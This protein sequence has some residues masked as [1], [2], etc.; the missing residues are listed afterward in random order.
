MS[1]GDLCFVIMSYGK[2]S[3]PSGRT[4]D[5]DRLYRDAIKPGIQ[6]AGLEPIRADEEITNG[7]IHT[8]M[9]ERLVLCKFTVADIT[10]ASANVF[11]E[12]G[13]RHA[14]KPHTTLMLFA[15]SEK[16]PFD[17]NLMRAHAYKL[18]EAGEAANPAEIIEMIRT[19][20][21]NAK[22]LAK[23]AS[24]SSDSPLFELLPGYPDVREEHTK[25]FQDQVREQQQLR[26][27]IADATTAPAGRLEQLQRI[28]AELESTQ[29][30][31]EAVTLE[32]YLA[33]RDIANWKAMEALHA[34]MHPILS[35][36]VIVR[37]Q[38]ALCLNRMKDGE[39]AE[40]VLLA[41]ID[42]YGPTGERYGLLGRVFKDRWRRAVEKKEE[43]EARD[44]LKA[45]ISY[46]VRGFEI[47]DFDPYPGVN[48]VTCMD[49]QGGT[50]PRLPELLTVV[51]FVARTRRKR[52]KPNYW[53]LA[54]ALELAVLAGDEPE[55]DSI[56]DDMTLTKAHAWQYTTT[57]DNLKDI[58][59]ARVARGESS[60]LAKRF[61]DSL[62]RKSTSTSDA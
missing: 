39:N 22:K 21:E 43:Q 49:I 42:E 44:M 15:D 4:V 53:D 47:G 18:N 45:A 41:L 25:S 19:K 7:V 46:Y 16:P 2:K 38:R 10:S 30:L 52:N 5:F 40:K 62:R 51:R 29:R 27:R 14:A 35:A 26:N 33:Y 28:E 24:P 17:V 58:H 37:E 13:V 34:K 60:E 48:A 31:G 3:T 36:T 56:W 54:T 11:Y 12:L 59:L 9:F 32:L 55:A 6:A 1:Q 23:E 20:L 50:D 61:M 8:A 57:A